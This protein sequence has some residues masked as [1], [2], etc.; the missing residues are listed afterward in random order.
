MN[1]IHRHH[2]TFQRALTVLIATLWLCTA[3][4]AAQNAPRAEAS[5]TPATLMIGETGTYTITFINAPSAPNL[6]TPRV[7]GLDFEDIPRTSTFQQIVNGRRSLETSLS[8]TFQATE[9]GTYTIPGRAVQISGVEITLPPTTFEVVPMDEEA[10]SRAYLRVDIPQGP[11]Y[12]GQTVIA[13]VVLLIRNDLSLAGAALPEPTTDTFIHTEFSNN[14]SRTRTRADGRLYQAL[15]WQVSLTPIVAGKSSFQFTQDLNLQF[16]ESDDRFPNVFSFSR[17][18]TERVQVLSEDLDR[19]IRP[20]PLDN[21]PESYAGAIGEFRLA[22]ELSSTQLM[23]GEPV[24][25]I[26]TLEGSGNFDRITAPEL[27]LP[28]SWRV[29]PPEAEFTPDDA[30]GLSGSKV[31]NYI[32]IPRDTNTSEFPAIEFPVFDPE[33]GSFSTLSTEA[34]PIVVE[35]APEA[36]SPGPF[37]AGV[38]GE[39]PEPV[40]SELRPLKPDSGTFTRPFAPSLAFLGVNGLCAFAFAGAFLLQ[41]HRRKSREDDVYTRR[42]LGNRRIRS[43]LKALDSAIQSGEVAP[44]MRALRA[45][46]QERASLYGSAKK[47]AK[48][49]A[50]AECIQLF[51]TAGIAESERETARSLLEMADAAEFAGVPLPPG[52][53]QELPKRVRDLLQRLNRTSPNS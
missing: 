20:V 37:I 40:P 38:P 44:A 21:A 30:F 13:R 29:Y 11:I 48:S 12:V 6:I 52:K 43:Q 46:L 22:G 45:I 36:L 25:F 4:V 35:A 41:R 2:R 32:L 50:S 16:N 27:G 9:T 26:L 15:V 18:R 24:S 47:E 28:E 23:E 10:R 5:V 19:E 33:N 39:A 34:V 14:P 51:E 7:A 17:T 49:L 8:W 31:F 42:N 3:P 1:C 53:L